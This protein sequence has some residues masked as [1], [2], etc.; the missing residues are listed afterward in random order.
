[1]QVQEPAILG[2]FLGAAREFECPSLSILLSARPR[3]ASAKT[4]P[5]TSPGNPRDR[6]VNPGW[7]GKKKSNLDAKGSGPEVNVSKSG[8]EALARP[9]TN[10]ATEPLWIP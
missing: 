4:L 7:P 9:K 8:Q 6:V 2:P 3:R 5:A 10:S 1:M